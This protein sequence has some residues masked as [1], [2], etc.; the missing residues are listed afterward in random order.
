MFTIGTGTATDGR[1]ADLDF[2]SSG[3]YAAMSDFPSAGNT[4]GPMT[5]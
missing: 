2:E 1:V 5:Q 4:N 3:A